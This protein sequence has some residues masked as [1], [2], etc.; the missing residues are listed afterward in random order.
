MVTPLRAVNYSFVGQFTATRSWHRALL[1]CLFLILGDTGRTF[2]QTYILNEDFSSASGTT[3][4]TGWLN[5]AGSG[6]ATDKWHFDNPGGRNINYPFSGSFAIFD[7]ENYSPDGKKETSTLET[8][9]FDASV[10]QNTILYFDHFF[11]GGKGGTGTVEVYNGFIWQFVASYSDSTANPQ[12]EVYNISSYVRGASAAKIRFRWEGNSSHYWAVDNIRVYAPLS[13]DAGIS[14]LEGPSMPFRSG[15]RPI[16]IR[17]TNFGATLLTNTTIGWAINN[18]VQPNYNWTGALSLGASANDIQIGSYNFPMGKPVKLK[19]WQSNP[20]GKID[21]NAFND[22]IKTTLYAYD[23][24]CGVYTVGGTAP[25]F[26][27]VSEALTALSVGGQTCAVTLRLR[28]GIYDESAT[29]SPVA[30]NTSASNSITLESESGDST[31]VQVKGITAYGTA[32][33]TVRKLRVGQ[34]S[35]G[36]ANAYQFGTKKSAHHLRVE[37]CQVGTAT[38]YGSLSLQVDSVLSLL[39]TRGTTTS[40]PGSAYLSGRQIVAT[41]NTLGTL[42][43]GTNNYYYGSSSP[44]DYTRIS[45]RNVQITGNVLQ[46]LTVRETADARVE[47][48]ELNRGVAV[49][50]SLRV[51]L[52][53]NR[54]NN[55]TAATSVGVTGSRRVEL[56]NNVF[57]RAVANAVVP[58]PQDGSSNNNY[59]YLAAVQL[60]ASDTVRIEGNQL[61]MAGGGYGVRADSAVVS[62]SSE[63]DS[64]TGTSTY[65]NTYRSVSQLVVKNNTITQAASGT[66]ISLNLWE[67]SGVIVQNNSIAAQN[68]IELYLRPTTKTS[69]RPLVQGNSLRILA[70][71]YGYYDSTPYAGTGLLIQSQNPF[72]QYS[73]IPG[74]GQVQVL[75]NRISGAGSGMSIT[76]NSGTIANNFVQAS[77]TGL[78][79]TGNNNR[80]IFNSVLVTGSEPSFNF[81]NNYYSTYSGGS[82]VNTA[83]VK[84]N[85]F[86]NTGTGVS[87]TVSLDTQRAWDWDYND[88][89]AASGKLVNT[90]ATLAAWQQTSS[91]DSHSKNVNPRFTS[92]TDLSINH[93]ALRAS[94]VAVAGLGKDIDEVTRAAVPDMGAKVYTP[95]T[96]DVGLDAFVGLQNPLPTGS[97]PIQVLLQNQSLTAMTS[98]TVY[99][100]VNGVMQP[101]YTWRG[102]LAGAANAVVTVGNYEF[103]GGRYYTIKAWANHPN[104]QPACSTANDTITVKDLAAPMCGV[105]T[106]GGTAPDFPTVSEALT[107]L[108]VG[109]Q[110]CAVTL[111]LRNGIYDES[112]T[113]SPV[114][115]N[116]SASNSITLES[117]S[118]D[119]TRVQVKGITA[120]GTAYLTVRKLR[121]GQL[122]VGNA[123]AYQFGT[124]KSA[125]HLRVESCQV[126]TATTYGSLSLQVD[127]VLSLLR[128]RGT[129]TSYPGSAYLSGRQI[130]A[131]KNTLGTLYVGTNNYYYGSSSPF[132]YTRISTRNVQI[133]GNVLQELTVRETADA[134]V[135]DNELNRGVAV[136][137][138]LRVSL[139]KNRSNNTTAATSVGVT[140]SRRV[141]LLNNVFPRAVAN[142]VVPPPQDGSSN[143]N[144]SYL[145]AVQLS[146]SDTVRIE[147]N[148]LTMAGG[149]Y[150]VR[151]DS[152]VVSASS[153]Y[154]SETG[155]ST[156]RNTYRS[157]S[158]LVVK[159]NTITQAASGTAISLNL[160]ENSGA[161][162]D[163][164]QVSGQSGIELSLR[165]NSKALVRYNTLKLKSTTN[166]SAGTGISLSARDTNYNPISAQTQVLAN[167]ISGASTGITLS[168][169]DGLVANNF[170]QATNGGITNYGNDTRILF[171]SVLVTGA[172]TAYNHQAYYSYGVS[173]KAV[174][175]NNVF[176]NTGAGQAI[177][178]YAPQNKTWDWDFNDYFAASGK[179]GTFDKT[180]STLKEWQQATNMDAHS[181]A[182]NP[183]FISKTAPG[184]SQILLRNAGISLT[185]FPKDIDGVTRGS[186]ADIGAQEYTPCTPDVGLNAFVDLPQQLPIGNRN[187]QVVLQN[188]STTS[189]S[190]AVVQWQVNGVTQKPYSWTGSLTG[191]ANATI[192]IGSYNFVGGKY[193]SV[194][195]WAN[196]PNGQLA[197]QAANDTI[198]VKDLATPMCGIYTVGG[199]NPD[200]TTVKE[201]VTALNVAGQTCA[202]TFRLRNGLYKESV[203][204]DTVAG[205]SKVNTL[206]FESES[207]DST[208]VS[209]DGLT[210]R[211]NSYITV[212]KLNLGSL[213]M[214]GGAY[215][216]Q[217]TGQALYYPMHYA[218]VESNILGYASLGSLSYRD[219]VLTVRRNKV[220]GSLTISG[221]RL[222]VQQNQLQGSLRLSKVRT[223]QVEQNTTPAT[224]SYSLP[225]TI[226]QSED[227]TFVSNTLKNSS[228][229]GTVVS[230]LTSKRIALQKNTLTQPVYSGYSYYSSAN[231]QISGSD[232]VWME[233]N[234]L[235]GGH[236]GV[237]ADSAQIQRDY[238]Y[239]DQIYAPSSNVHLVGNTIRQ[240]GTGMNLALAANSES[241]I[242][243]NQVSG[244][245][246]IYLTLRHNSKTLVRY[247]TITLAAVTTND[248]PGTG[249]YLLARDAN[250]NL[251]H[252]QAQLLANRISGTTNGI[253]LEAA[254]GLVANNFVQATDGGITNYGNDTRILFNSV[255]VTGTGTAYN[256]YSY[257]SFGIT[258]KAV[259]KNNIFANTGTG[260]AVYAYAPEKK[261][262]DW[263]YNDYFAANGKLGSFNGTAY[264]TLSSWQQVTKADPNSKS[265]NPFYQSNTELRPLQREING[266]GIPADGITLDIDGE[267]RNGSAPDVGGDEFTVDFGIT[268]LV[269]PTLDCNLGS[270]E[271][272]TVNIA[273]YG[274]IPLLNLKVAYQVNK[275]TIYTDVIPGSTDND[276]AYTFKQPQ[277]LGT[278]GVY[279]FK[280]WLVDANDDNINN[281]TL[282]IDRYKKPS[283]SVNFT[284]V[285]DCANQPVK[286]SGSASISTGSIS[287]YEW[288]FGD[289]DSASVKSPIH[290]YAKSG[291]YTVTM[292][293]YSKE[294]CYSAISKA[295]TVI[296]TPQAAFTASNSCFGSGITFTNTSTI[297]SGTMS[298]SWKFGDGQTS[299][300]QHPTHTYAKAGTYKVELT[301]TG[302]TGCSTTSATMV[303]VYPAP[304]VTTTP[305]GTIIIVKGSKTTLKANDGFTSY[306]WSDGQPYQEVVISTPGT[307]TVTVTDKNGCQATSAAVTVQ[308]ALEPTVN[309]GADVTMCEG[310][311]KT[312]SA[313]AGFKS[314]KWS[315]GA[316][317]ASITVTS[318]GIYSVTVEDAYGQQASDEVVVTVSN[319]SNIS[320]TGLNTTYCA[321]AGNATLAGTPAGGTFSGTGIV[322]GN[323]FS[324]STAGPGIH[325]ITYRYTNNS[326][327]QGTATQQVTVNP[328][329]S[330]PVA[331]GASRC[332]AGT[333][334]LKASGSSGTY[335]WYATANST[336]ILSTNASFVTHSLS[337]TT[338]YY[339]QATSTQGCPSSRV[340]ATATIN[341]VPVVTASAISPSI[342]V[343]SSTSLK[344]TGASTYSWSP[345]TG[346]STTSGAT[347]TASPTA[348]TT[349]IVTGRNASGCTSTATVTVTVNP[350][351]AVA[352]QASPTS[353]M[354]GSSTT[355]S[356]ASPVS[357]TTYTWSGQGLLQTSGSSVSAVPTATGIQQ[358]TVTATNSSCTA[359][360]SVSVTV[361]AASLMWT[362]LTSTAWATASNWSNNQIPTVATTVLIPAGTPY[363]PAISSLQA[364]KQVTLAQ[365]AKL[366][367]LDNG[368]LELKGDFINNGL[369]NSAEKGEVRLTGTARQKVGGSATT[370]FSNL[371]VEATGAELTGTTTVARLLTLRGNVVTSNQSFTLLSDAKTT[372]MVI[373]AGGV[374]V[375]KAAMQ[376]YISPSNPGVGYRHLSSP[377]VNTTVSDL[378]TSGFIPKVN[379]D[380][381]KLPRPYMPASIFPTVL[382]FEE[383]RITT[384]YPDFS[385]GWK[386][387]TAL[388]DALVPGKGYSV[389]IS[390]QE[391]V[392]LEGTLTTGTVPVNT[393]TNGG[394]SNSGWHLL[395]N[396]Y[397]APINW[398]LVTVPAGMYNAIYT[399]RSSTAYAGSYVSYVNGVGPKGANII[400]AMQGFLVRMQGTQPVTFNFTD[401][402]RLTS[403]QN[404][405]MHR[406]GESRPL[407]ELSLHDGQ[408][409]TDATYLYFEQ[410]ATPEVDAA[411]DAYKVLNT[412][413]SP[414]LYSVA[415]QKLLSINGQGPLQQSLVVPLGVRATP[416]T[417]HT[418]DATQLVNFASTTQILLEDRHLNVWQDLRSTPAYSFTSSEEAEG[419]FFLHFN[420][421]LVPTPTKAGANVQQVHIYPNP[422][423]GHFTIELNQY[424]GRVHLELLNALGQRVLA[425]SVT[426]TGI[427]QHIPIDG[428]Q[429]AIGVYVVRITSGNQVVSHKIVLNR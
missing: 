344:A 96:P 363:S 152:A 309:L 389:N 202:V 177:Y 174:V 217:A 287:R 200:F 154:D 205:N 280:I 368:V 171:N 199:T 60:S 256:H 316:T 354:L 396:P 143:N 423:T 76:D 23:P 334:T 70:L 329:L 207:G 397:P 43:V 272:V 274:D 291:T 178:V 232:S 101:V 350:A 29:L 366:T 144:Y 312:L 128:T 169:A 245:N 163:S 414:N 130:V 164:N 282:R 327:C 400:P 56:L 189:M 298:Y 127:S 349:Y 413:G 64:E 20:N 417:A 80:I 216:Q 340:S 336:T 191:S 306:R 268:R 68:G 410:G 62:A 304:V 381:N 208:R 87:A 294:G 113:L 111:R 251:T 196:T 82:G 361:T 427:Q 59:S 182:V 95:C 51:S 286:F 209:I 39:R 257:Y 186:A 383:T 305:T 52:V 333:V 151:A 71:R 27:T 179:L 385:V 360:S 369:F 108:S 173:N 99:W 75:N 353:L 134:R 358:Y 198:I 259:V 176:A 66:A 222:M 150:G 299:T 36:N 250:Y 301:T 296:E 126:G 270:S 49:E 390:A 84:N 235:T 425:R 325:T 352:A 35:V 295:V 277:D 230:V 2:A 46:E 138:S 225:V 211:G 123:N 74:S 61:T 9:F 201:A 40:Y 339:V 239:Y 16:Q 348:T 50:R 388:T 175:K 13:L 284:Y 229:Y 69:L 90:Q 264:N 332:G 421:V 406:G 121:V 112:A 392:A 58:P 372:A 335:A 416:A 297:G 137:R 132:D 318:A 247:N 122:S 355:L 37:S 167:R 320:F 387:P 364:V 238:P 4:P 371:T 17:L 190:S 91:L 249:I 146:A 408:Q 193:Y 281:D 103:R 234:T 275:G 330:V 141:E 373:N 77:R 11:A 157:V 308:L 227:V 263:D 188:Q 420:P 314:Y 378:T 237:H 404:P 313:A 26:P 73:W 133:T 384:K 92:R 233:H 362:G 213:Y 424:Q 72:N 203:Q 210:I 117:E 44:F 398:D 160:W 394:L 114:A 395:G 156:Y 321:T 244:Q 212:R 94:G 102:S 303:T 367:V 224:G 324:P 1:L 33:L 403:Y 79:C 426:T 411:F 7:S 125:H 356:V 12:S 124:K 319:L 104:G 315:T 31:R 147:G 407:L 166:Y 357:G 65:R 32:Y 172:G 220:T 194:K 290:A 292:R 89:F 343:G 328:V 120:Y 136:E 273:Q 105:Y 269:S 370:P 252:T 54:S 21:P 162:I 323:Q 289:G 15:V 405:G 300:A 402:C 38:T 429:L 155:T 206:T 246:G 386:S 310:Q 98:A 131:T 185:E 57:P 83:T 415:A 267:L 119:S 283:P 78:N 14:A 326:G 271:P 219:S 3:P 337:A 183:Y 248:Q 338:T 376:R 262:W 181:Q 41:K 18:V 168:A 375:G 139:V 226:E 22:T 19:V 100:Q 253:N 418:L 129:T 42:Y 419:R 258:N 24:M 278:D 377:V 85:L 187:I 240:T 214:Y 347:V 351:L 307:Y 311:S 8:R 106:V 221:K 293:A 30:G 6:P 254:D 345:A 142:A 346:L 428:S 115:G 322:N 359:T 135:E 116:T 341:P 215:Y 218:R 45:T 107:A 170:V 93:I 158:Q 180:Y 265:S 159:N 241:I 195:A 380:Y 422:T 399:F 288:L 261:I 276:I 255:L 382:G 409:R 223:A 67:N 401:A 86:V 165:H 184:I 412:D 236:I 81:S 228:S 260:R 53:K 110:T 192:S 342:C 34:L 118:G 5:S 63:Y 10:S 391:K 197:C 97:K 317:T 242:D 266:A 374:V 285:T 279:S 28:N 109:G 55:T 393:L 204:L 25:D 47:D 145:A 149:G 331:T 379:P 231:V 148:Q 48:N 153:E 140:G 243:S 88:Y 365:N 161:V 302:S